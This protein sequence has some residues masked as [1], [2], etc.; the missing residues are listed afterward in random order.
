MRVIETILAVIIIVIA[1]S[2]TNIM[3]TSPK[4]P[5][6][7]PSD[8]ERLGYD[9]LYNLDR[10]EILAKFVYSSNFSLLKSALMVCLPT[11]VNFNLTIF[12][13]DK[14]GKL[15]KEGSITYGDNTLFETS[16]FVS[17]VTYILA[18]SGT[19]YDPRI[20]VLMLVRR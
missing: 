16:N 18:G 20:L 12:D 7:E 2:F 8:L 13:V 14:D 11:D 10:Q 1:F 19:E 5:S 3:A 9:A 17:T 6:Y 15:Q 4:S